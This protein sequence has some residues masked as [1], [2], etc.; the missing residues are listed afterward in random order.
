MRTDAATWI[1]FQ[2]KKMLLCIMLHS[3]YFYY[4]FYTGFVYSDIIFTLDIYIY[5]YIYIHTVITEVLISGCV[6][7]NNDRC[8]LAFECL[9]GT[10]YVKSAL[11]Y[12]LAV[13]H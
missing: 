7:C 2:I 1:N 10:L 6:S 9:V 3:M 11:M 5:I 13:I 4:Y 8:K 12:S